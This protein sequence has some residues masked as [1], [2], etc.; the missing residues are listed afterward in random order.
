MDEIGC[1]GADSSCAKRKSLV[2]AKRSRHLQKKRDNGGNVILLSLEF[3]IHS[4][5][6]YSL[7]IY[8]NY[9]PIIDCDDKG[10]KQLP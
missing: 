8:F 2:P 6:N 7:T 3:N 4:L 5:I 1:I 9:Y 10:Q